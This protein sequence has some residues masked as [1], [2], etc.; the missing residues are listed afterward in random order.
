LSPD[1]DQRFLYVADFGNSQVHT[2]DRKTLEIVAVFG[3]RGTDPGEFQGFTT[4]P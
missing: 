4:S 2:V 3:R 1:A